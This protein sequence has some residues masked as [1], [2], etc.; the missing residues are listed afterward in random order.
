MDIEWVLENYIESESECLFWLNEYEKSGIYT[1]EEYIDG[2]KHLRH[3]SIECGFIEKDLIS[4]H[5]RILKELS[6]IGVNAE[7]AGKELRKAMESINSH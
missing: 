3:A 1:K 2:L 4:T 7:I 5:L 6:N